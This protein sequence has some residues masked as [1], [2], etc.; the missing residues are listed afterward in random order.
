[1]KRFLNKVVWITGASSGIGEATVYEFA[2]EGAKLVISAR[3]EEELLRVK[4]NTNLPEAD[5][6]VLPI[7][8]EKQG[9]FPAKVN[10]VVK[11]F[12]TI[13]VLFNNA[14]I[15]QRSSVLESDME[16]YHKIMEI[17]FFGVVALTKAVLPIMLKQKSGSI[18]VTS[19]VS[20]K[21][22]TPMRSGYCATKHALHG[23]FD[24]LRAEVWKEN[25]NITIIC[26]GYIR[27]SIS[28]NAISGDG[29]KHGRMDQNQATGISPED[30]AENIVNAIAKGKE[31]VYIGRKEVLGVYLKRFFP[32]ILSKIMRNQMPK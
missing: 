22:G 18:A 7:D 19:S 24:S 11:H 14:G 9:E 13:D 17:N 12:G 28:I 6:L 2:K 30:C 32:R 8:V 21:L 23:F 29:S 4:K 31:E 26:P 27:T 10:Q 16:V 3:R 1:M 20:G 15:S 5:I 25:I